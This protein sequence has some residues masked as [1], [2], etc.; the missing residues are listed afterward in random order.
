MR[1]VSVRFKRNSDS[2]SPDLSRGLSVR[3]RYASTR[4]Q[5]WTRSNVFSPRFNSRINAHLQTI[6]CKR[7]KTSIPGSYK[8][9]NGL[10]P[11]SISSLFFLRLAFL[12]PLRVLVSRKRTCSRCGR[13]GREARGFQIGRA[14]V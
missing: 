6:A 8:R 13:G 7:S 1:T 14:H 10:F 5:R 9:D 11:Y 4:Y 2:F 12:Q 3:T